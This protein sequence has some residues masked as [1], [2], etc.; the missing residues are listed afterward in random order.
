M[1]A[2]KTSARTRVAPTSSRARACG[3][4][5]ERVMSSPRS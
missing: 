2:V 4:R 5:R 1:T 3:A